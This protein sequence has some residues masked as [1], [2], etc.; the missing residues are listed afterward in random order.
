MLKNNNPP[1]LSWLICAVHTACGVIAIIPLSADAAP[2]EF[3][4]IL[5]LGITHTDNVFL[6]D[7]DA[8]ESETVYSIVPEFFL[9]T[10][11]ERIE[12]DLRYRPEAY[13]YS[14]YDDSDNVFHVVDASLTAALVKDRLFLDVSAM[15][16]QSIIDPEGRIPS[17]NIPISSNRVDSQTLEARPYWQQRLGQAN[18]L[19][20]GSFFRVDYDDDSF[21]SSNE[22]GGR[23]RLDNIE[24]QEGLAW[25]IDYQYR[26]VEYEISTPWEF[27]RAALDLGFWINGSMRI[28]AV[29]GAE[30]SI[31]NI[32]EP[33]MDADF[34]EAGVQYKPNQR[35]NFE[36]AAGDRS[37]GTS[38]RADFSYTLRRGSVSLTYNEGPS[39]RS[40]IAFGYRPIQDTDNLDNILD[41]PG[42]SDRF[43]RRRGE[44]QT[45]I[46]LSKSTLTLRIFAERRE[47]RTTADGDELGDE[48][49]AGV[50]AQWSWNFGTKTT[51]GISADLSRRDQNGFQDQFR[52][53]MIDLAYA[54]TGRMSLR[55]EGLH[56]SQ[57]GKDSNDNDYDENQIRLRLRTEF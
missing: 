37:Y 35:L 44:F 49:F 30:T 12:A 36:V 40:E 29:G 15:N 52:R 43:L 7:S 24:R 11:G 26:R 5:D 21:Q 18:L 2:W 4:T 23:L 45:N 42:D 1:G 27:Q 8:K 57:D 3:G 55:L 39:N 46:D 6:D 19:V 51:L 17:G 9:M 48:E 54:F 33:N 10:D 31:E 32:F 28:F 41:R 14:E 50:A 56:T 47:L 53:G 38:F 22:R 34:W 16:Y 13:F 20:E 25:G